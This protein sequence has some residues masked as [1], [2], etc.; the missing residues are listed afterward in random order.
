MIWLVLKLVKLIK[1]HFNIQNI[2]Q[3]SMV[4]CI[5]VTCPVDE[6]TVVY[7]KK[8]FLLKFRSNMFR[9]ITE[10]FVDAFLVNYEF[11]TRKTH[12]QPSGILLD[13][14]LSHLPVKYGRNIDTDD[15]RYS[16]LSKQVRKHRKQRETTKQK[17][18]Y[19]GLRLKL[20]GNNGK[21][22]GKRLKL[23]NKSTQIDAF[24]L[25]SE[26]KF[27]LK[28]NWTEALNDK[29][30]KFYMNLLDGYTTYDVSEAA[31][32]ECEALKEFSSLNI[33]TGCDLL[34]ELNPRSKEE[35]QLVNGGVE[36]EKGE[37]RLNLNKILIEKSVLVKWR[38]KE[39]FYGQAA[40][41]DFDKCGGDNF[42]T[43]GSRI[44]DRSV[45]KNL[46]V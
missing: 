24:D 44:I 43:I 5:S 18:T 28:E 2:E 4:F 45:F 16:R 41:A 13:S 39:E 29:G 27:A 21:L 46:K 35:R 6:Y 25:P 33:L 12:L 22:S 10:R 36:S 9:Q 37:D 7:S 31:V 14:Y 30:V 38:N 34:S 1:R 11:K 20:L 3:A 32:I 23:K 26:K 8:K 19:S 17:L 40:G 42:D 15:L